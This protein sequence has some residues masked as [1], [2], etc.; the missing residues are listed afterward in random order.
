M[1]FLEAEAC[2]KQRG[3]VHLQKLLLME[4]DE[5]VVVE[6]QYYLLRCFRQGDRCYVLSEPRNLGDLR[7]KFFAAGAPP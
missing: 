1:E 5:F 7:I 3:L 6:I 4:T 2:E